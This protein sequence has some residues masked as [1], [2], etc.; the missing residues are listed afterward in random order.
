[1]TFETPLSQIA[2]IKKPTLAKLERMG[3]ITV[4]DLLFHFPFR[5]EDYSTI[6]TIDSLV[7]DE[8]CTIIGT[9]IGKV[10]QSLQT[11]RYG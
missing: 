4:R 10:N 6:H 2:T 3:L 5:Y 9:A 1:M 8:K 7:P 11:K